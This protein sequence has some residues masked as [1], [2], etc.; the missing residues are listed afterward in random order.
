[1]VLQVRTCIITIFIVHFPVTSR[2]TIYPRGYAYPRL[3]ITALEFRMMNKS[4]KPSNPE[5]NDLCDNYVICGT[6]YVSGQVFRSAQ[7]V[8]IC[9]RN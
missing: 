2:Y 1:M 5:S 9:L 7:S 8:H 6:V 4:Q 3:N